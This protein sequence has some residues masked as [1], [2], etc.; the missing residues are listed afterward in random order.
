[1]VM[2]KCKNRDVEC[3][4]NMGIDYILSDKDKEYILK[5]IKESG[6]FNRKFEKMKNQ[7]IY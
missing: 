2:S 7:S 1:M 3:V 5:E 6:Y 4:P